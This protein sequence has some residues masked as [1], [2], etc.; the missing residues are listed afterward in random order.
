MTFIQMNNKIPHI[1]RRQISSFRIQ[2]S[3]SC[4]C[5]HKCVIKRLKF[6]KPNTKLNKAYLYYEHGIPI[7]AYTGK[8]QLYVS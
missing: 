2:L 6:T 3:Y 7:I 5:C 1:N 8:Q 4:K